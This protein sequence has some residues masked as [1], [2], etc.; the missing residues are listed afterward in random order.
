M[1]LRKLCII[2]LASIILSG[3]ATIPILANRYNDADQIAQDAGF[4]RSYIKSGNFTLTVYTR[5]G[6]TQEPA[7]IYIEGDGLAYLN[8]SRISMDPTPTNP[9]ALKLA[10]LDPSQNVAYIA[11]PGQFCRGEIPDCDESYWT[12]NRFSEEVIRSVDETVSVV[13]GK[14]GGK[15]INLVGFS[16]GG[17]VVCLIAARRNDIASIRTVAGNLDP[18][19]VNR[20]HKVSKLKGSLNPMDAA[21]R[22]GG[23]PQRHFIGGH[24]KIIPPSIAHDFAKK[25]YDFRE[26]TITVVPEAEHNKG[27]AERWMELLK[28]PLVKPSDNT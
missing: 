18:D 26:R 16:G 8:R 25:S 19:A 9:V 10:T 6:K 23:I 20:F 28:I 5:I 2:I 4:Q 17:A 14:A 24:D 21:P 12:T 13:K 7:T 15:E 1:Y 22:L 3:C 11:R 27:W